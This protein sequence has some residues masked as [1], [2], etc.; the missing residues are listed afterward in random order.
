MAIR[1]KVTTRD[2]LSCTSHAE[3]MRGYV[4]DYRKGEIVKAVP[5]SIGILVFKRRKDA[6]IFMKN[7]SSWVIH[8][9]S[10]KTRGKTPSYLYG[11]V[12]VY[13]YARDFYHTLS[14][15]YSTP[16]SPTKFLWPVPEGT[17]AYPEVE[18][19]D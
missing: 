9:V 6:E 10:T 12:N 5:N 1:Y 16:Y 18:V 4:L 2:R 14:K 15:L 13:C 8:R 11:I 19:L 7:Q 3:G 17:L